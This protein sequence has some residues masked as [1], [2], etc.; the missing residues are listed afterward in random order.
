MTRPLNWQPLASA[1]PIPGNAVT[2]EQG[3]DHYRD[4][5]RAIS[6]ARVALKDLMSAGD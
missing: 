2:V 4:I 1:D 3:A 5:S 6:N